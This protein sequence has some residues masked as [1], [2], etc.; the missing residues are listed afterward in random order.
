MAS[1]LSEARADPDGK[2]IGARWV[3]CN[4]NDAA[5]PDVRVRLVAQEV[6]HDHGD[7][8]VAATPPLEAKRILMSHWAHERIRGGAPLKL[9]FLGIRKA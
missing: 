8:Y 6:S 1:P 9:H 3:I 7:A 2:I 4:K 5:N